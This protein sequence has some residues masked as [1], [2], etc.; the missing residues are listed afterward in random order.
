[1]LLN[2][3]NRN[4]AFDYSLR[5]VILKQIIIETSKA[6]TASVVTVEEPSVNIKEGDSTKLWYSLPGYKPDKLGNHILNKNS[7]KRTILWLKYGLRLLRSASAICI[8]HE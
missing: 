2:P 4:D 8:T 7:A 1:M 6:R 5:Q 3:E